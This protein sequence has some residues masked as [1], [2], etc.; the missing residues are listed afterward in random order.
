MAELTSTQVGRP[1]GWFSFAPL[2][3]MIVREQP[4]LLE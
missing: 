2:Y 3:E 4:D 1:S